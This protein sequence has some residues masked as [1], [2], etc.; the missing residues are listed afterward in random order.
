MRTEACTALSKCVECNEE[1][2]AAL[3]AALEHACSDL[4]AGYV[5]ELIVFTPACAML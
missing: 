2:R 1:G 3:H 5:I 4:D